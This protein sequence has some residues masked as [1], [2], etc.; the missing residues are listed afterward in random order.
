MSK[1]PQ[2]VASSQAIQKVKAS[3]SSDLGMNEEGDDGKETKSER[4]DSDF[5]SDDSIYD[6][7]GIGKKRKR[8]EQEKQ[9][10][11][12]NER[13]PTRRRNDPF[14]D[15]HEGHEGTST[16]STSILAQKPRNRLLRLVTGPK[17]RPVRT[18]KEKET[19]TRK[20]RSLGKLKKLLEIPLDTFC[21]ILEHLNPP[22][23]LNVARS[24]KSLHELIVTR[25][26]R[27]VW[28]NCLKA[29]GVP[30]LPDN[31][32]INEV[33][34][35]TMLFN[36]YCQACGNSACNK[37]HDQLLVRLCAA[38]LTYNV[39]SGNKIANAYGKSVSR[40]D[41]KA[42]CDLLPSTDDGKYLIPDFLD[43]IEKYMATPPDSVERQSFIMDREVLTKEILQYTPLLDSWRCNRA[44]EKYR[45]ENI[46]SKERRASIVKNLSDLGYTEDEIAYC[47]SEYTDILRRYR[48]M[49]LMDQPRRLTDKIWNRISREILGDMDAARKELGLR[50]KKT[51]LLAFWKSICIAFCEANNGVG[52]KLNFTELLEH[53]LIKAS[54]NDDSSEKLPNTLFSELK[55][56][57]PI[58]LKGRAEMLEAECVAVVRKGRKE[59]GLPAFD[60]IRPKDE[61]GASS[62]SK[63]SNI[64]ITDC[65]LRAASTTFAGFMGTYTN[66]KDTVFEGVMDSFF[67]PPYPESVCFGP[68]HHPTWITPEFQKSFAR[69]AEEVL[70]GLGL[71][72]NVTHNYMRAMQSVLPPHTQP[73]HE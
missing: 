62:P 13:S 71:P 16:T 17:S 29:H 65:L 37:T 2:R 33:Q 14:N 36:N 72:L 23:L 57:L 43:T 22:D 10:L 35:A 20:K 19:S 66:Q 39:S 8:K 47:R 12:D 11:G 41:L 38:C 55:V 46:A 54:F 27:T 45:E 3:T 26:M 1:R 49:S 73:L 7:N 67:N 6:S 60:S 24:S 4:G 48:V 34:L 51:E 64:P 59:L 40:D 30:P 69:D 32:P 53:P 58:V 56:Q 31:L 28:Q 9:L 63:L 25:R 50:N 18:I 61:E 68:G 44:D 52:P 42:I 5:E 21:D 70:V 15:D